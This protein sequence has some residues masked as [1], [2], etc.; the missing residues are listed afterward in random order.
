VNNLLTQLSIEPLTAVL[1]FPATAGCC[2]AA[3]YGVAARLN[4]RITFITLTV[5]WLC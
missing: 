5:V 3:G 4:V 1:L 2:F